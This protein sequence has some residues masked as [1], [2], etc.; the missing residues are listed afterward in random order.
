MRKRESF[1]AV[2]VLLLG[3]VLLAGC[4]A[5][6]EQKRLESLED[7]LRTY[8]TA[9]RW[10]EWETANAYRMPRKSSEQLKAMPK[11]ELKNIRVTDYEIVQR[12][13]S[14]DEKLATIRAKVSYYDTDTGA[15]HTVPDEQTWWYDEKADHWF[16][17]G[18]LPK[19]N[20]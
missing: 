20:K 8:G 10:G 9:L 4:A 11:A 18:N 17:D 16:L 2:W 14:P 1:R 7:S 6:R 13:V 5:M 15:V 19:F 3:C 12:V